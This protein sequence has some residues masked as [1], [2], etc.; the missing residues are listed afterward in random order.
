MDLRLLEIFCAVYE[1]RG[2][3]KAA[4]RLHLTQP[5]ISGHIRSLEDTFG[6]PLFDRL[7]REIQPTRA[8]ELLYEHGRHILEIKK[9]ITEGMS[10]FLNR[11]AGRLHLSASTIPGEY[12][13][14]T[15]IGRFHKKYPNVDVIAAI[16]DTQRVVKDVE[17]GRIELG[18]VG[19]QIEDGGLE[20]RKFAFDRLVLVVPNNKRWLGVRAISLND[21]THVPFLVRESGSGTRV[22]LERKLA[23][24][25]YSIGDFNIVAQLGS[26]TA[27]KQAINADVGVSIIS[28]VAVK[29]ELHCKL[30]R[31]VRIQE[32]KTLERDFFVVRNARRTPSPACQ[33]F[34]EFVFD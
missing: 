28:N 17:Q 19:A 10:K 34:L 13:L 33:A 29:H 30:M 18:F 14:P 23:E 32:M 21:L 31:E 5:T 16:S 20:F 3:S 4:K 9:T 6:T 22:V 15:I 24:L 27:I 12:L 2:F 26:T 11:L 7:G 8:G 1:E 25:G